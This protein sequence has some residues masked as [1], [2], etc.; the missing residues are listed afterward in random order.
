MDKNIVRLIARLIDLCDSATVIDRSH[1]D[2]YVTS[3]TVYASQV[4]IGRQPLK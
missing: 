4:N 1:P 2:S 3:V